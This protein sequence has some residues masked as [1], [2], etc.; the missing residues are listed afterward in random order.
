MDRAEFIQKFKW[1][2]WLG[3]QKGYEELISKPLLTTIIA[4]N[5]LEFHLISTA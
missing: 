3:K 1:R 2:S 5:F 4:E